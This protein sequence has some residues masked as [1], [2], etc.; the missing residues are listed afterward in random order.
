MGGGE[1]PKPPSPIESAQAQA[2]SQQAGQQFQALNA[3]ILAAE[4]A[5]NRGMFSPYET[6][7]QSALQAQSAR[8][9]ARAN[10]SIQ[11]ETD[12]QAYQARQMAMQGANA[13]V[14]RL[15]GADPSA[16]SYND[17]RAFQVPST[18][19]IPDMATISALARMFGSNLGSV[20]VNKDGTN[21]LMPAQHP[22]G[23]FSW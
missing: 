15:Y 12:P 8:T 20:T 7:L 23:N 17:P 19:S 5:A 3:P 4:D 9:A 18:S 22:G 10:Q 16:F 2:Q 21:T 13:R 11:S 1:A 14:G 6:Q